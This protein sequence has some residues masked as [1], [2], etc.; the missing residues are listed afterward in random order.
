LPKFALQ[1]KPQVPITQ[2]AVALGGVGHIVP[3]RLQ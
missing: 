3:Q 2:A 1:L